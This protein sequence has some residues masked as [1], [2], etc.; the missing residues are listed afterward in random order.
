MYKT[1]CSKGGVAGAGNSSA[2][3]DRSPECAGP[4]STANCET[5]GVPEEGGERTLEVAA[6]PAKAFA[7]GL[8][9]DSADGG[10]VA[11]LGD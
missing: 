9:T 2:A 5:S 7:T 11:I 4:G 10:V 1:T 3:D 6:F 8:D